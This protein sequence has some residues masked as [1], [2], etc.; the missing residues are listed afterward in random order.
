[1]PLW[2]LET[3]FNGGGSIAGYIG[4]KSPEHSDSPNM[5][6]ASDDEGSAVWQFSTERGARRKS[7]ADF[8][9][10]PPSRNCLVVVMHPFVNASDPTYPAV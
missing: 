9:K 7:G 6:P 8:S 5:K 2:N 4:V 1:V 3:E 10:E